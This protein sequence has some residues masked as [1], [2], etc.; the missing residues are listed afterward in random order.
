MPKKSIAPKPATQAVKVSDSLA[1]LNSA[2]PTTSVEQAARDI[3]ARMLNNISTLL[4]M[5]KFGSLC[6]KEV[7][8]RTRSMTTNISDVAVTKRKK[9]KRGW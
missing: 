3:A 9:M 8:W 1:P 4:L 5:M 7:R 6:H 2:T